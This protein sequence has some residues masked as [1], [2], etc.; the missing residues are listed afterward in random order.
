MAED[1]HIQALV[2]QI[3]DIKIGED[4]RDLLSAGDKKRA[5][6]IRKAEGAADELR[7]MGESALPY[8]IEKVGQRS[9][10]V[11]SLLIQ[12]RESAEEQVTPLLEHGDPVVRNEARSILKTIRWNRANGL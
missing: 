4:W 11:K 3:A 6:D 10:F 1:V 12:L 9:Y 2:D 5:A 7:K 8:L